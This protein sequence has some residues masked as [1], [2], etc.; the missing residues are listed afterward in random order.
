MIIENHHLPEIPSAK[1]MGDG[2]GLGR[3]STLL[4]QKVEELTLYAIEQ[5][6]EIDA[7]KQEVRNLK[8]NHGAAG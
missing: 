1:E 4:L 2:M 7:L 5:K 6:K 3:M 8:N